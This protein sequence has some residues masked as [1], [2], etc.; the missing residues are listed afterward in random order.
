MFPGSKRFKAVTPLSHSLASRCLAKYSKRDYRLNSC[1][2]RVAFGEADEA[3]D[4]G[5]FCN[6]LFRSL[7]SDYNTSVRIVDSKLSLDV[8]V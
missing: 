2:V 4:R 5:N 7:R 6:S 3:I 8:Q 1:S